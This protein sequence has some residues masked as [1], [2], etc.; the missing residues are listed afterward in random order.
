MS[1]FVLAALFSAASL[2]PAAQVGAQAPERIVFATDWLAQAEH[3]GFY[4]ARRRRHLQEVR[5]R[6]HDQDGRPAGQRPAAARRRPARRRHGR[7]AAGDLGRRAERA[8]H[9]DRRDVPEES[10]GDHRASRRR[11]A[12]R[13]SRAS[14]SRSAP[15]ATRRSGPGSSSATASPTTR[16]APTAFSVQP[17]LADPALS[18][19]GFATSEPFSI[20]KGGVKPVVFLLADLGYPPYSEVLVVTRDTL[21]K[22]ARRA[23]AL[24][25][26]V[27]RRLE[28]LS[29]QSGAGQRAHQARQSAR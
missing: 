1:R 22:R 12:S 11:A 25:S 13:I 17:F 2:V 5:P 14:R 10:D 4:Q 7:R 18:Q 19:Q 27:G 24:R 26:R 15:R 28:E 21:D 29:R 23:R 8:G 6:R 3:G 16:S 20:E 9:R